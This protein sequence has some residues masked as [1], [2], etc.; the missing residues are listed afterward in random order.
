MANFISFLIVK[1]ANE[2]AGSVGES[3]KNIDLG[4]ENVKELNSKQIHGT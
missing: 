3:F 4:G 2:V 1:H